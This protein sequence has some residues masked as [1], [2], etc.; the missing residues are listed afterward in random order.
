MF[1]IYLTHQSSST[2]IH[3]PKKNSTVLALLQHLQHFF[4]VTISFSPREGG[5]CI[6]SKHN[7]HEEDLQTESTIVT[8]SATRKHHSRKPTTPQI[9][10]S[11]EDGTKQRRDF[12]NSSKVRSR[13]ETSRC[14][15][16]EPQNS[17]TSTTTTT[18][19][20]TDTNNHQHKKKIF[21]VK[22]INNRC[23]QTSRPSI[24][25]LPINRPLTPSLC[26]TY[27]M[28]LQNPEAKA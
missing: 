19:K 5:I 28:H 13:P 15:K 25:V 4:V 10:A 22:A 1:I 24:N 26:K 21:T 11:Q 7:N 27:P 3:N 9:P 16:T 8:A 6:R 14:N 18:I 17:G 2:F 20:P 12:H 23:P